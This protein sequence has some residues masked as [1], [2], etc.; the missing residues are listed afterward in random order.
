MA[1]AGWTDADAPR[2]AQASLVDHDVNDFPGVYL[3]KDQVR[4]QL[5]AMPGPARAQGVKELAQAAK[6]YSSTPAFPKLYDQWIA[7]RFQAVDHG[8]KVQDRAQTAAAMAVES[9]LK[10]L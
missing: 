7:N 3:V 9:W 5:Q 8:I 4:K 6:A 1:V 10:E 2:V